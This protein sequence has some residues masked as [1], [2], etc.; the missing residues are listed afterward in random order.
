PTE[1]LTRVSL[2]TENQLAPTMASETSSPDK[3]SPFYSIEIGPCI[4]TQALKQANEILR[5]QGFDARQISGTGAVQFTRMLE[6]VY[7]PHEA[8]RRLEELKKTVAAF[9]WPL[10]KQLAIYVGSFHDPDRAIRHMELLEQKKIKVTPTVVN[11]EMQGTILVVEKIDRKTAET[12]AGQVSEIGLTANVI[13]S[14]PS[15]MR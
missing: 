2:V 10:D 12:I 5:S 3:L 14:I 1:S 7:P 6:G 15:S 13:S 11:I 8:Y 9:V 4:T